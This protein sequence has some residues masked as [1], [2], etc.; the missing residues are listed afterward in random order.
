MSTADFRKRLQ[1][2][3]LPLQ[4]AVFL[5]VAYAFINLNVG[6]NVGLPSGGTV[7]ALTAVIFSVILM[8]V[9]E[10]LVDNS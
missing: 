5:S 1:P 3:L 2:L 6:E 7:T 10:F 9:L 4:I 8:Y